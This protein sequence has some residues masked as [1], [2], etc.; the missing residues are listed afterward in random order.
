M[1]AVFAN[2]LKTA[3]A[4]NLDVKKSF[5]VSGCKIFQVLHCCDK[6]LKICSTVDPLKRRALAHFVR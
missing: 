3:C 4:Y 5:E 1:A 2:S 6:F